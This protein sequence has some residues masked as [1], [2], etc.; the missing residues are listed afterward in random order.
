MLKNV[1]N[2]AMLTCSMTTASGVAAKAVA[3]VE[4]G[5]KHA[6]ASISSVTL[7]TRTA[8]TSVVLM[9]WMNIARIVSARDVAFA[10]QQLDRPWLRGPRHLWCLLVE[11]V[12]HASAE[13]LAMS[14]S[15]RVKAFA[16]RSS[17][18]TIASFAN[19]R[20]VPCA[21]CRVTPALQAIQPQDGARACAMLSLQV[22]IAL[23][24]SV[25]VATSVM[26]MVQR[27]ILLLQLKN[28][29]KKVPVYPSTA[30]TSTTKL[31]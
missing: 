11:L 19:A 2:G 6:K 18:R 17:R 10:K 22:R 12:L 24:A 15:R 14:R 5:A 28:R 3:S 20:G 9:L 21:P 29:R 7:T 4:Q 27:R 25:G 26:K 8:R 16:A 23:C 30:R 31:A 1:R 13:G